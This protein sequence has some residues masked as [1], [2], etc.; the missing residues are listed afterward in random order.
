MDTDCDTSTNEEIFQDN[1]KDILTGIPDPVM[2]AAHLLSNRLIT[3]ETHEKILNQTLT[4][5]EKKSTM[6]SAVRNVVKYKEGLEK[7]ANV[8]D[9][10]PSDIG[11]DFVRL[12]FHGDMSE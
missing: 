6:L 5:T 12:K 4:N 2:A 3:W 9:A 8:L 11:L 10:L 7:F 1:Y